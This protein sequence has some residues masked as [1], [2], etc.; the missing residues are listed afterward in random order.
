[1]PSSAAHGTAAAFGWCALP[2]G[3]AGMALFLFEEK[4]RV[5]KIMADTDYYQIL[6]VAKD[7]SDTQIKKAYR[8]LAMTY[9]PDHTKGDKQAEDKFKQISEAYAVLSDPEKRRQYD[10]F[11]SSGFHQ[12]FSRED[13]FSGFD[14]GSIFKEFGLGDNPFF[15]SGGGRRNFSFG[16]GGPYGRRGGGAPPKGEDLVYDLPL[17]LQEMAAGGSRTIVLNR[18]GSQE[19][20]TV[21][22]PKGLIAGK[23]LRLAGKGNASPYGGP[24]GDLYVRASSVADPLF[25]ASGVDVTLEQEILLTEALLGT[26]IRIPTL[27]GKSLEMKVPPGTQPRTRLRIPGRGLPQMKGDGRGDLF[28][29]I[30]VRIPGALTEEQTKLIRQLAGT[31]L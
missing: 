30:L 1:M 12:R 15:S 16:G 24:A 2:G 9:H 6:G 26:S 31:G 3:A 25:T 8:K 27:S 17:T 29:V 11:G 23:K 13:I 20:L 19:K 14:F 7:A 22:I 10:T 28:V 4:E 5:V 18:G 21:R